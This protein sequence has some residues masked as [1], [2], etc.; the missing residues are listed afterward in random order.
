M[1]PVALAQDLI[2]F[3]TTNPPG[4]EKACV[5]YVRDLL[6]AAGVESRLLGSDPNRPNLV[7]RFPGR[8]EAPPL[9]LH[10]HSDV[11]PVTGQQW[12]HPPF[13]GRIVDGHLWGRGAIDMK[14]GLAMMLAAL[15]GLHA[16]GERPAGDVILAVVAD[17]E[18]GSKAGAGYLV[19]EHPELFEGVRYA[20]G[21]EGG[22]GMELG[23]VR[24]HPIVVGEKRAGWLR[25]TLRGPG[26][27]GSRLSPPGTPI[28]QLARLLTALT[29]VRLPRHLTPAVDRML[30]ALA[31]ALP[32][33]LA[34]DLSRM[35][36]G[37]AYDVIP[38]ALPLEEGLYLD[39]LLRHTVNPTIVRTTEKINVIPAEV[40]VDLDGRIL[41]G[42]FTVDD[43]VA[44]IRELIG[45][46]PVI[47]L[48]LEGARVDPATIA[49]PEFGAFYDTM[50]AIL[51]KADPDA[52]PVPMVSPASTD[53]RLF[54]Q[55]GIRCYGWLPMKVPAGSGYRRLLHC[56]DE[57]IP[58][59]SLHFGT[60]CLTELLRTF[61]AGTGPRA[62][63]APGTGFTGC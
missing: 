9:L 19:R 6:A 32:E 21:E 52:V 37:R 48:L 26:G 24:M 30:T 50:A 7:A 46:E 63:K 53:A 20:I 29:E 44:E 10:A 3:D 22:A 27:H 16:A 11:V 1:D 41:P 34:Q 61:P 57:R 55:L 39:S 51:L 59:E 38:T 47:E 60:E 5:E 42:G 43:F 12:T 40:T 54:A 8:G 4:N 49:E 23:G 15:L 31:A 28:A 36:V 2:R 17:E 45:P 18:D 35:R 13:E 56:A 58:V 62:A 14:G 33:P 25:V